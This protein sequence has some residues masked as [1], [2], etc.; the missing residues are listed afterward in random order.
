MSFRNFKQSGPTPG[1]GRC[2]LVCAASRRPASSGSPQVFRQLVRTKRMTPLRI[3]TFC[4][5][6]VFCKSSAVIQSI[7]REGIAAFVSGDIERNAASYQLDY[8]RRITLGGAQRLW[9]RQVVVK[10][11]L[12][13]DMT[14]SVEVRTG[15]VVHEGE[16]GRTLLALGVELPGFR[17]DAVISVVLLNHLYADTRRGDP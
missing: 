17:R 16:A 1:C 8:A 9:R 6:A 5:F 12:A 14:E 4:D 13:V 15:V 11:I 10:G 2:H 3:S 7:D